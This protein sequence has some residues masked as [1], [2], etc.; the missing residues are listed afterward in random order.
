M[1]EHSIVLRNEVYLENISQ[2]ENT[3]Q[4]GERKELK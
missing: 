1:G 3:S 4:K 2:K